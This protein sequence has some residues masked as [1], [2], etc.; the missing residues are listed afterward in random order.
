MR[1][2]IKVSFYKNHFR[3]SGGRGTKPFQTSCERGKEYHFESRAKEKKSYRVIKNSKPHAEE[4]QSINSSKIPNLV[5]K[6][7]GI[8]L[9]GLVQKKKVTRSPRTLGLVRKRIEVLINAISKPRAK[10]ERNIKVLELLQIRVKEN[11]NFKVHQKI[12]NPAR[13]KGRISGIIIV[14]NLE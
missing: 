10:E 12:L 7:K 2:R 11:S 4:G 6:R 8:L 1:R 3:T 13:N 5:W 14:K 9:Q